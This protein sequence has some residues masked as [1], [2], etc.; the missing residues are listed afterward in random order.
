M[1]VLSDGKAGQPVTD[2]E[3]KL[4][5]LDMMDSIHQFCEE[6]GIRYYLIGGTLLGAVRHKGFIPWDDDIDIGMLREDYERFCKIYSDTRMGYQVKCI[7]NDKLYYLPFAKVIDPR[8]SLFEEVHQAP[9]IG[10]YI[11][12]F[13]LDYIQKNVEGHCDYFEQSISRS[14]EDLRYMKVKKGRAI[15]KNILILISRILCPRSLHKIACIREERALAYSR[16]SVEKWIA[17]LHG[18][19]G[20]REIAPSAYFGEGS[21]YDFEGRKYWGPQEYDG[22]LSGVYGD[23]MT[24]PPPEKQVTHHGFVATWK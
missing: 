20:E 4:S 9:E 23:Y 14:L 7:H 17:N 8:I 18:A 24:P 10:A 5:L 12:V 19:W 16:P 15:W 1:H 3:L 21:L 13:P 11:D 22:Y 6:N 2:K